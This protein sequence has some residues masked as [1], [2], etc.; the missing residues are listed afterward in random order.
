MI[1]PQPSRKQAEKLL[2]CALL[3]ALLLLQSIAPALAWADFSQNKTNLFRGTVRKSSVVLRKYEI[4]PSGKITG[5]PLRGA[6]FELYRLPEGAAPV[7]V[8]GSYTTDRYGEITIN[9]LMAGSYVFVETAPAY[10]YTYALDETGKPI[11]EYRF[12]ITP[13]DLAGYALVEV[14]AYNQRLTGGLELVKTVVNADGSPLSDEQQATAFPFLLTFS[15]GESYPYQLDGTGPLH[16]LDEGKLWLRHGQRAVFHGLP[17]GVCYTVTETP[18]PGYAVQSFNSQGSIQPDALARAEFTNAFGTISPGE[19]VVTIEK[20]VAGDP[21]DADR[22]FRFRFQKNSDPPIP[23]TLK[24]GE[25]KA[26]TLL[27]GDSYSVT[28]E[29]PFEFGYLLAAA[30][31]STGTAAGHAIRVT[32]VNVYLSAAKVTIS[33]EKT[34]KLN[35]TAPSP[36]PESITVLLLSGG[37]VIQMK[38]V[39]PDDNGKWTYAFTVPKLDAEGNEIVYTIAEAP[40][41]GFT[42]AVKGYHL[43]NT[44]IP[45]VK[46]SAPSVKK[47][48]QGHTP[49]H[50]ASFTF[51][52]TALDGA[53]MPQGAEDGVKTITQT[54]AGEK[55]FGSISFDRPGVYRY[56]IQEVDGGLEGYSYDSAVY[57]LTYTVTESNGTLKT[58]RSYTKNGAAAVYTKAEFINVFRKSGRTDEPSTG[59]STGSSRSTDAIGMSNTLTTT[60]TGTHTSTGEQATS[61]TPAPETILLSGSKTWHHGSNPPEHW[62]KSI[63]VY[64]K[65]GEEI[66]TQAVVTAAEDWSYHFRLP[67]YLADGVTEAVYTIEEGNVPQ[68]THKV[69]GFSLTNT[70]KSRDYPGDIPPK[71]G[72]SQLLQWTC[73]ALISLTGLMLLLLGRRRNQSPG[74]L[75]KAKES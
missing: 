71:T 40:L 13:E 29:D 48:L 35:S 25:T 34:W 15:N 11:S 36:L 23:F 19:C 37:D 66:V 55:S 20:T 52:L 27:A 67:R 8:G 73:V 62:P 56:E 2:L 49:D 1:N 44:Q 72:A 24:A 18:L 14:T 4:T 43:I 61:V 39:R 16:S 54:G 21:P 12:R 60:V 42:S 9:N 32:F 64:V 68:Y 6:E 59:A 51:T 26:F 50:P 41:G 5:L 22:A 75:N 3:A 47:I 7:Q 63:T 10:G 74:H 45:P 28:E 70:F 30:V 53:P 33:G 57:T 65:Q 31:N 46:A 38:T 58:Q 69:E 17:A